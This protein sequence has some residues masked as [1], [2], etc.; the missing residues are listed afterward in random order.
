MSEE[1]KQ[2]TIG[3]RIRRLRT[4]KGMTQKELAKI[5]GLSD[6]TISTWEQKSSFDT[7]TLDIIANGLEVDTYYLATGKGSGNNDDIS[8]TDQVLVET[9]NTVVDMYESQ[10]RRNNKYTI[11]NICLISVGFNLLLFV[12]GYTGL[13]RVFNKNPQASYA[14]LICI[15]VGVTVFL[16]ANY[17]DNRYIRR[18]M[19]FAG[20]LFIIWAGILGIPLFV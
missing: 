17:I 8:D 20:L 13:Y 11:F 9:V 14:M 12:L 19:L 7:T 2:E 10:S 6:R 15:T 1:M 5:T 18:I 16:I 3:M 4:E